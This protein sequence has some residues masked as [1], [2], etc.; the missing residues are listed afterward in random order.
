[1]PDSLLRKRLPLGLLILLGCLAVPGPSHGITVDFRVD[2]DD[3]GECD[4]PIQ[5]FSVTIDDDAPAIPLGPGRFVFD[6]VAVLLLLA[7]GGTL[8]IDFGAILQESGPSGDAFRVQGGL[9]DL[10]DP[11]LA[12]GAEILGESFFPSGPNV[13]ITSALFFALAQSTLAQLLV[14]DDLCAGVIQSAEVDDGQ[15][16]DG[17]CSVHLLADD[18]IVVAKDATVQAELHANDEIRLKKSGTRVQGN[19]TAFDEISLGANEVDGDVVAIE[20]DDENAVVLGEVLEEPVEWIGLR[21]VPNDAS[22]P[23]DFV[24]FAGAPQTLPPGAYDDVVVKKGAA[25]ELSGPYTIRQLKLSKDAT[26]TVG[27]P[28]TLIVTH[29]IILSDG[30]RVNAEGAPGD[31]TIDSAARGTIKIGKEAAFNGS[32]FAAH[33][34]VKLGK[35]SVFNG[36]LC[37]EDIVIDKEALVFGVA[38]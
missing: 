11:D 35:A 29:K 21:A 38:P 24:V 26:I 28:T 17:P 23:E 33:A 20:V 32:I 30:T 1:M 3:F 13:P 27:G 37:V 25:L 8:P 7:S 18:D 16:P 4:P 6:E 31:L 10:L 9:G 22:G 34:K 12:F 5:G 19:V 15:E 2:P 36:T 14:G